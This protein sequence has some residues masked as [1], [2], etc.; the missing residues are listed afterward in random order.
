M[1]V[2]VEDCFLVNYVGEV[3]TVDKPFPGQV[4]LGFM[5]SLAKHDPE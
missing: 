1:G 3:L 5:R 4:F 2:L